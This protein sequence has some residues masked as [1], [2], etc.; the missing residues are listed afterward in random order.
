MRGWEEFSAENSSQPCPDTSVM[1][2]FTQ[3]VVQN[4]CNEPVVD[5]HELF[6]VSYVSTRSF[7]S[8]KRYSM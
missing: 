4:D 5:M 7:W 3:Q 1:T 6:G 2:Q 8:T